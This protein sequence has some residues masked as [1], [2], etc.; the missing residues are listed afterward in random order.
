MQILIA[1]RLG[2]L[3]SGQGGRLLDK[4]A[5]VARIFNG[6]LTSLGVSSRQTIHEP[7]ISIR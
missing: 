6:L 5:E 7:L 2:Y 1:G 4:T 3:N